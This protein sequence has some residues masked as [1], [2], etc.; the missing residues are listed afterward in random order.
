MY[1]QRM[2]K[3]RLR[4]VNEENGNQ[5]EKLIKAQWNLLSFGLINFWLDEN[6]HKIAWVLEKWCNKNSVRLLNYKIKDRFAWLSTV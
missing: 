1:V 3:E 5:Q 4:E 2:S 6:C